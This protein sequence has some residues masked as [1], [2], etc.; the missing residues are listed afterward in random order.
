[1]DSDVK[2]LIDEIINKV[3][4]MDCKQAQSHGERVSMSMKNLIKN[5]YQ[6]L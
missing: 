6:L 1:M 5:K 3:Q 4:R 2:Y